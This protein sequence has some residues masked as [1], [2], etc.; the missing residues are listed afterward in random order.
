MLELR[1]RQPTD[2]V[3][4]GHTVF[5]GCALMCAFVAG[6]VRTFGVSRSNADDDLTDDSGTVTGVSADRS[7]V[8][9]VS[10]T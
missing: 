8:I 6:A 1:L 10:L 5:V 4:F 3:G 9:T 7:L 2:A